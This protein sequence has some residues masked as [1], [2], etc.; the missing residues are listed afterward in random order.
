MCIVPNYFHL[1]QPIKILPQ[2][3]TSRQTKV[4]GFVLLHSILATV[5]DIL[6]FQLSELGQWRQYWR[7]GF[8]TDQN[9]LVKTSFVIFLFA[10]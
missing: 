8:Q 4:K 10:L 9:F 5:C 6:T 3:L 1:T 7:K 2:D